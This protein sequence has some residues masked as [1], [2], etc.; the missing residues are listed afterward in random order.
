MRTSAVLAAVVNKI[1]PSQPKVLAVL[2][3]GLQA[4]TH[5]EVLSEVLTLNEIRVWA[6]SPSKAQ[7]VADEV[8]AKAL[9][10]EA[11]GRGADVVVTATAAK[12]PILQGA[13]LKPGANVAAVGWS[14]LDDH[15]MKNVVIVDWLGHFATVRQYLWCWS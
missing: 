8:G 11:A 4:R 13:W 2:G 3:A 10:V 12:E 5:I 9:S 1:A 6:R 15:A 14:S 7:Y